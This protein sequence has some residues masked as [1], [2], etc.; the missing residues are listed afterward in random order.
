MGAIH[1]S[2]HFLLVTL[3]HRAQLAD[4]IKSSISQ[5]HNGPSIPAFV[6]KLTTLT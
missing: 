6:S 1:V 3:W 2:L 5:G 4:R